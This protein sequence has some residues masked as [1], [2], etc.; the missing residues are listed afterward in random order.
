MYNPNS[1]NDIL[2]AIEL[3]WES[4]AYAI[5][6]AMLES[7]VDARY[8]W[9][10][11]PSPRDIVDTGALGESQSVTREGD[12][13]HCEW[14]NSKVDYAIEVHEGEGNK[15]ARR[16]TREAIRGDDAAPLQWQNQKAILNVPT[17]FTDRFRAV[18]E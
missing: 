15:P 11:Q 14:G 8:D 16:W 3:A 2:I 7:I 1:T 17:H 5:D 6:D 10:R 12:T 4:T 9:T 13:I 18:Y